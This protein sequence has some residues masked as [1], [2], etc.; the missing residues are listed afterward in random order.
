M[1]SPSSLHPLVS[2]PA[3]CKRRTLLGFLAGSL[4]GGGLTRFL[5]PPFPPGEGIASPDR[6][7]PDWADLAR[8]LDRIES[9][10]PADLLPHAP[11]LMRLAFKFRGIG[12]L[13]KGFT[14][15]AE[16]LPELQGAD[17]E[18]TRQIV[19]SGLHLLG[20]FDLR[21]ELERG[22]LLSAPPNPGTKD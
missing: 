11:D 10:A 21:M 22:G 2:K 12:A 6:I 3:P 14:K 15:L 18:E 19:W 1:Q 4:F 7:D 5:L 9:A 17:L 13:A 8:M 20:R 16:V